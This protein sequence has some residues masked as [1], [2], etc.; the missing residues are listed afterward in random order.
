MNKKIIILVIILI[1]FALVGL[2]GIQLYWIRNAIAVKEA[3]F[4]RG[5]NEALT[6]VIYKLEKLDVANRIKNKIN[7]G[8]PSNSLYTTIDSINN[9]FVK[10]MESMTND[11]N[12]QKASYVNYTSKKVTVEYTDSATG[13][14]IRKV[15]SSGVMVINRDTLKKNKS[16]VI[17]PV[18]VPEYYLPTNHFDSISDKIDKFL[19]KSF[20]VSDVFEEMY[21]FKSNKSIEDRISTVAL[22]SIIKAELDNK[23]IHTEFEYGIYSPVKNDVVVEKT[24]KYHNEL[25]EKSVAFNLFPSDLFKAPEYLLI[26][27]PEKETYLFTQTWLMLFI[28]ALL[29]IFIIISFIYTIRTI[30]KQKIL[31]EMKN[32]FINNMTHEFKTPISTIS[33]A[34]QALTDDDI[35]KSEVLYKNYLYVI[36]DE[37]KRLGVMAEKILQ[38]AVLDKGHV[39]LKIEPMDIHLVI[40]D[41]IKNISLQVET[42]G[43]SISTEFNAASS[44]INA[45]K[46]HITNLI[47][48]LLD[49]A[50]K[51]T[52]EKPKIII[53]TESNDTG[54]YVSVED[55]GIG[56][57]HANLKKIFDKLYRVPTGNIHNVKGF[58]LGLS[59]VKAIVE[60][61][62]GTVDVT[63]ELKKGSKFT[64]Y[65]PFGESNI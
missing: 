62:G 63:S 26:Y 37:N 44:I 10:E 18:S 22:D 5:V 59:Y 2:V 42:R 34:C 49:N 17:R 58:G 24:G 29:I 53:A 41:V 6:S 39:K 19:K 38:T 27:F 8:A 60:M 48:N 35:T 43:G 20:L 45:D 1:S 57:S 33:L 55:N 21:N 56:I 14:I 3:N 30:I 4:D 15:D 65:L 28:A 36:N 12:I 52:P 9:M 51:Y 16:E 50:N 40:N 11:F 32:D 25:M 23:G 47:Y 31:S 61:H 64:I 54:I 13:N 46:V 7:A